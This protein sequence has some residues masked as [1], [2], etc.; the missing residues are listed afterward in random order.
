MVDIITFSE[1]ASEGHIDGN[2]DNVV[3]AR[4][5]LPTGRSLLMVT[6]SRMSLPALV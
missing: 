1:R 6:T 4:R 2:A 3:V 5:I